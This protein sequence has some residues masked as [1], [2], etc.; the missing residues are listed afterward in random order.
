VIATNSQMGGQGSGDYHVAMQ[1]AVFS[2][3]LSGL[4]PVA[5][6]S[7]ADTAV[8]ACY[9]HP[10]LDGAQPGGCPTM[11]HLRVISIQIEIPDLTEI[12]L[13]F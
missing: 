13:R 2:R 9:L 5:G 6:S 8:L 11:Y 1:Q 3:D 4:E 10:W 7:G 12:S